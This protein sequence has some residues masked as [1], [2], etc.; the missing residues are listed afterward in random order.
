MRKRSLAVLLLCLLS[1]RPALAWDAF[2]HEL[3]ARIAWMYMT[4]Q[5]RAA[6]VALLRQAPDDSD[7]LSLVPPDARPADPDRALFEAVA[8]WP[9]VVRDRSRVERFERYAHGNWHYINHYFRETARG[10]VDLAQPGPDRA[11]IVVALQHASADLG[12][13]AAPA[14]R[15]A[16]DLAW[17]LH[18]VGDIHQPLHAVSRVTPALPGGDE[19]GNLFR[20]AHG[21]LHGYWDSLLSHQFPPA[22][23]ETPDERLARAARALVQQA[24]PREFAGRIAP[25]DFDGWALASYELAKAAYRTPEGEEPGRAY[26]QAAYVTADRQVALAGYRLALLLSRELGGGTR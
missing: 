8:T 3:I 24:P 14:A 4:P 22:G 19:G 20:L 6:A 16:I 1:A 13:A 15:R 12:D 11:N 21:N 9:D 18:L 10:P 23:A 25:P 7:L 17:V 2:G 26:R 5:A